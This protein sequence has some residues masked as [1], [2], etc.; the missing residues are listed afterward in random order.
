MS[1]LI[2]GAEMKADP[3]PGG[4][5]RCGLAL[6]SGCEQAPTVSV[7]PSGGSVVGTKLTEAQD[8]AEGV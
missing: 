1:E 7:A 6:T 8:K 5:I 4:P 2:V 3:C